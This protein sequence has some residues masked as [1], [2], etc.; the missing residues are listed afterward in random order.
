MHT[1]IVCGVFKNE[2]HILSEWI[3]H[4]LSRGVD[5]IYL[6]ND[7]STDDFASKLRTFSDKVTLF[8]NDIVTR[9]VGRQL[10]IYDKYF[11]PILSSAK[12]AAILDLDEF[13]YSPTGHSFSE[14]L[15]GFESVA[16][17]KIDWLHFGSNG[18]R[19]QPLSV[20]SGFTT[21]ATFSR[22][23]EYYS[24]K[25]LFKTADLLSF[26]VH[27]HGVRG[28]TLHLKYSDTAVPP[29]VINH[30]SIQSYDFYMN[31]KAVRGDI[32]NWFDSIQKERNEK[33]FRAYDRNEVTDLR[34][35][36][37]KDKYKGD[38]IPELGG[39]DEVTLVITSCNRSTLLARTLA[40]FVSN[41]TYPIASTLII[42]DSG[43][44][45][46]N[47][48]AIEPYKSVLKITS[49]YNPVN[50]G[51]IQSIDKVYSYVR[52]RWIF[53]CEEDWCFLQPGFI[54]KSLRVF[55]EN[56]DEKIYTVWLRPHARTSGHPIELDSLGRGYY[57]MKRDFSYE[58]KG[59]RY[60]WGG[61]TFNPG[62]RRTADCLLF[63]PY[64]HRC[65]TMISG[66][67]PYV[68]EYTVNKAYVGAGY[69]AMI[70]ADPR[71][72]VDHIG[73][74]YHIPRFWEG[75]SGS[76]SGTGSGP[77]VTFV[78]GLWDIGRG[79][80][81][82][83]SGNDWNRSFQRYLDLLE[84]LLSTGLP[85]VVYG[86]DVV[87]ATVS[88]YSNAVFVSY[89]K[90]RFAVDLP[91][92][93]TLQAIRTSRE[94][95]DQ[96]TAQWLKDSPQARLPLYAPIV[97]SKLSFVE[98]A[99]KANPFHSSRFYWL[100]AGLTKNHDVEL[101]R[102]IVPRLLPYKKFTFM[103]HYYASNTEIHGFLR[104]GVHRYCGVPFVD[105]IM[106][107][108]LWGGPADRLAEIVAEYTS[109]IE[110]SLSEGLLGA[111]E[112]IFTILVHR[113]PEWFDRVLIGDCANTTRFL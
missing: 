74:G 86:D 19:M 87:K 64:S 7:H 12:W 111:E 78:T 27:E 49:I 82:N 53:H 51:Q 57:A 66:G 92:Y 18:H 61:I 60:T 4:Y 97:L 28:E 63:H 91:W 76:G 47:E 14:L 23:P 85:I 94:W 34:L 96:P 93:N 70:L 40:S 3:Q 75:G 44:V 2:A 36:N 103:S 5:H 50:L 104:E 43:V 8:H 39:G 65:E 88:K 113:K 73:E 22:T 77:D 42:D 21:R 46:C 79:S 9:E 105:R 26:Q 68:G 81:S 107:G 33:L 41:N 35:L 15:T 37:Q 16:Q 29:L 55:Q 83:V 54:E 69:S 10:Q 48:T 32:N 62:L 1:F 6:V 108:F 17:L 52:T 30:Y 58:D 67:K 71:G 110:S 84:Q 98:R 20:V 109:I 100:D 95:Y 89:P 90:E 102:S 72:H 99:A 13:L 45:G 80:L 31:V 11:R 106:K 24:Y 38:L 112:T 101:L 59:V 25:T 56:P